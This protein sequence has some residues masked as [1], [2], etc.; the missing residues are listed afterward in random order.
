MNV[1]KS[2]KFQ[3]SSSSASRRARSFLNSTF[4]P[5]GI[6]LDGW[7]GQRPEKISD[8]DEVLEELA[9]KYG[10]GSSNLP[11]E[12]KLIFMIMTSGA[13][14][15]SATMFKSA[16]IDEVA[17]ENPTSRR[18]LPLLARS[19]KEE[20]RENNPHG[21]Y[22]R[23]DG[24]FIQARKLAPHGRG[25]HR[26]RDVER[27]PLFERCER[28]GLFLDVDEDSRKVV[29]DISREEQHPFF[30]TPLSW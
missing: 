21:R 5:V 9:E 15:Q 12:L 30:R 24:E 22:G 4:D 17:K 2:I 25:H 13:M 19:R 20:S 1:E 8:H 16:G 3:Q 14:F 18:T 29:M 11:P 23:Y 6:K 28:T 7:S 10:S 27:G 26:R